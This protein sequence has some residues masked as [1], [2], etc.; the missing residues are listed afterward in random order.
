[1]DPRRVIYGFHWTIIDAVNRWRF[2]KYRLKSPN[3]VYNALVCS[4]L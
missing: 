1:L 4:Y 2:I 3:Y